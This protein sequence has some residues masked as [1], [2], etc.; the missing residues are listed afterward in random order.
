MKGKK[1]TEYLKNSINH[2]EHYNKMS[3]FP[4]YDTDYIK[5]IKDEVEKI[6]TS[7]EVDYDLEPV[8]ACKYCKSLH[9][10][11]DEDNNDVCMRCGSIN[12]LENFKDIFEYEKKISKLKNDEG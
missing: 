6:E 1:R 4:I 12:E 10:V 5:D 2:L 9:I 3:P 8:V 7:E 11:Y